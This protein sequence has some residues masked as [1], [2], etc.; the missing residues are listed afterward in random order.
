M[1]LN[2]TSLSYPSLI[3]PG[4]AVLVI[5]YLLGSINFSIILTKIIKKDDIRKYGS[6]NAGM[7]NVLRTVGKAPA[8]LTFLL[9]F[10]KCVA[11]VLA[12]KFII[13]WA[14]TQYGFS[15]EIAG[16][17][18]YIAGFA[19]ILG[20]MFPLYFGFKGGKGVVT[21]AAMIVLVDWRCFVIL[22]SIFLI[23]FAWKKIVSLASIIGMGLFPVATFLITFFFDYSSSPLANHGNVST[24]YLVAVTV[25]AAMTGAAVVLK[26]HS[27]IKRLINGTEKPISLKKAG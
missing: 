17:G 10:L 24:A 12:G 9:D 19:C 20:H 5:A 16:L 26:H 18:T 8:A 21:S 14:C 6:G 7:T 22:F 11:A 2:A 25:L 4:L 27:N 1:L 23:I 13:G 3:L 15:P